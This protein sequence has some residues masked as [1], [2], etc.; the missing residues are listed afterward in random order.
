MSTP[1][2]RHLR[3]GRFSALRHS[4]KFLKWLG[5]QATRLNI[6]T[7]AV[8]GLLKGS[9]AKQVEALSAFTAPAASVAPVITGT[10]K[11]GQTL[12]L[13]PGTWTGSSPKTFAYQWKVG[14]VNIAGATGTTYIPVVGNIGSP[15]TAT[16]T[17]T[18][19]V[20]SVSATTAA[21]AN[22]IA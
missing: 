12:T 1:H 7:K 19:I 20:S 13:T 17:A 6:T 15:I 21:T 5:V 22:V 14:G 8:H 4:D 18:N 9:S 3:H 2:I 16:V 11:V 10:A